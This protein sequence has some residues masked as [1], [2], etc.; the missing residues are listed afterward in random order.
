MAQLFQMNIKFF[1]GY[2]HIY[3]II[4]FTPLHLTEF[5]QEYESLGHMSEIQADN[6]RSELSVYLLHHGN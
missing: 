5:M 1:N 6:N 2:H 3:P 4:A